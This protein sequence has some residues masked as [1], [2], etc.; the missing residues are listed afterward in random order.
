LKLSAFESLDKVLLWGNEWSAGFLGQP[1]P[2]NVPTVAFGLMLLIGTIHGK[3]P[4]GAA[5]RKGPT[6]QYERESEHEAQSNLAKQLRRTQ[7]EAH[8][9]GEKRTG[10][11][12]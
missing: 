12:P 11:P 6:A 8:D 10:R 7:A 4:N 1:V 9:V 5:G 3:K 2:L